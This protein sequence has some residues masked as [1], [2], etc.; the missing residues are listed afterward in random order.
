MQSTVSGFCNDSVLFNHSFRVCP[1]HLLES[2]PL[3]QNMCRAG[4]Q[5]PPTSVLPHPSIAS[6][7]PGFD[8]SWCRLLAVVLGA[9]GHTKH[10]HLRVSQAPPSRSGYVCSM[11]FGQQGYRVLASQNVCPSLG[12]QDCLCPPFHISVLEKASSMQL[13]PKKEERKKRYKVSLCLWHGP[14]LFFS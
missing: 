1:F 9:T 3:Q 11:M 5:Q 14:F 10:D 6:S 12:A 2:K 8:L 13:P 4:L 7:V